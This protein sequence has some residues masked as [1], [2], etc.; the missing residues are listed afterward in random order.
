MARGGGNKKR[1][2]YC[3]DPS[4]QE[5]LYLRALHGH[6]GRDPID[7][8]LQDNVIIPN[9]FF[10]YIYH[11]GCAVS[12]HFIISSGFIPGGQ[13]LSRRQTVFFLPVDPLDKN[14]KGPEHID[15]SVPRRA[16]YVHSAWKKHQDAVFLG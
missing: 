6:A 7:L 11:I 4:G 3:T 9:I 1:F 10:E 14:H 15:F 2:Q 5:I 12:S 8:T 16:R 13:S